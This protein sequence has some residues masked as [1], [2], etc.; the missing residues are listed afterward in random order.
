MSRPHGFL[1]VA[2]AWACL[3]KFALAAP[4]SSPDEPASDAAGPAAAGNASQ[5]PTPGSVWQELAVLLPQ[6]EPRVGLG[7]PGAET[8]A[9]RVDDLGTSFRISLLGKTREYREEG[10]DCVRRARMGALFVALVI[11]SNERGGGPAASAPAAV[12]AAAPPAVP[13]GGA[14]ARG[15][16]LPPPPV[17]A[18]LVAGAASGAS[19]AFLRV[20]AGAAGAAGLDGPARAMSLGLALRGS[21]GRGPL[22]AV[23]GV[24]AFL[25]V[26]AEVRGV[27]RREWRLPVDAGVRATLTGAHLD[28]YGEAGLVLALVRE[29]GLD[30]AA[31]SSAT[32]VELGGRL[33]AG[34]RLAGRTVAPY[35]GASMEL[36][37]NPP[38]VGALPAGELGRTPRWWL[39]ASAG[40]SWGLR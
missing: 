29:R 34:V 37:P 9:L 18:A 3:A 14:P 23:A 13:P 24:G 5:C 11:D 32:T 21:F 33:A 15:A 27:R 19:R 28:G 25:P 35:V 4:G 8:E 36:V 20:E 16:S 7:A 40:V 38:R 31:T 22:A 17:P 39:G 10:R 30:L 2:L 6:G 12:V 26:D 1:V